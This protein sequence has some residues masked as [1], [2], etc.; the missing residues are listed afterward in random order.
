MDDE[1]PAAENRERIEHAATGFK[2][3]AALVGDRDRGRGAARLEMRFDLVREMMHVH[4]CAPDAGL[5]QPVEDA[6]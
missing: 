4:H 3:S 2:N 5:C 6:I 1:G